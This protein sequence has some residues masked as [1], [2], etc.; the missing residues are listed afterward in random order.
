MTK[1]SNEGPR[2]R[3]E[4]FAREMQA[5]YGADLASVVLYGSAARG[6]YRPGVSDLN[7]LVLVRE[8]TPA[9]LR[10]ASDAARA[11]VAEG[12]PPP[13][14]MSTDEWRGSADVWAIELADMRD[15]HLTVAG[16]DP[17]EGIDIRMED[18]RMQCERELKGKQIQLRER[19]LLFAGQPEELGELLTRSFS[20]F[21]V[22]FRTVL[23]L[24]GEPAA[25]DAESVVRGVA[26]R[27]G[28]D[29]APLLE[30]HRARAS[31]QKPRPQAD[32][33][34]VV[35]YLDAVGRVVAYVDRMVHGGA[36]LPRA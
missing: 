36:E 27:V 29:P 33:P 17:F 8:V 28:F 12:N 11:F 9:A 25:G 1:D 35:G 15:A 30:I 3:A 13:L 19:Y 7:L 26:E 24:G 21:L 14:M 16:A 23:R 6:E 20:T 22:L 31:G 34:V 18:L 5:V 2:E 4:R 10:R 32:A